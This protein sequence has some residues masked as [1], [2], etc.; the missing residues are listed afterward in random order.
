MKRTIRVIW[1]ND[2]PRDRTIPAAGR[3]VFRRKHR[4]RAT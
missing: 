1:R 3:R 2:D 4:I